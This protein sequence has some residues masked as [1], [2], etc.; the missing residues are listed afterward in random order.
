PPP[1]EPANPAKRTSGAITPTIGGVAT[2]A[3]QA[4]PEPLLRV[5]DLARAAGLSVDTIRFYQ[6]RRLL[7]APVRDGRVAWYGRDHLDRLTPIPELQPRGFSLAVIRRL[8]DG[9]LDAAD[10]PLAA[11]IVGAR[12]GDDRGELLTLAELAE[13][14]GVDESLLEAVAGEGLLVPQRRDGT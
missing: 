11:A 12:A 14:A 4:E 13:R 7:P 6:K 3:R 9:E 10:E 2:P 5:D 8:L 1:S